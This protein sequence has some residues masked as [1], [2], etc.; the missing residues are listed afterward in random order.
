MMK[1]KIITLNAETLSDLQVKSLGYHHDHCRALYFG[2]MK[3]MPFKYMKHFEETSKYCA[4]IE[5][6]IQTKR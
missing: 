1:T 2:L 6:E 4:V 3:D 5:E